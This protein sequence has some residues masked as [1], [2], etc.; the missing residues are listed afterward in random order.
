MENVSV[1]DIVK[2]ADISVGSFYHHFS[3]KDEILH[4]YMMTLT[5]QIDELLSHIHEDNIIDGIIECLCIFDDFLMEQGVEFIKSY[6]NGYN[7]FL[8]DSNAKSPISDKIVELYDKGVKQ[9][10]LDPKIDKNNFIYE[11]MIIQRG[12][13]LDYALRDGSYDMKELTNKFIRAY[14]KSIMLNA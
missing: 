11:C 13:F 4:I 7:A 5:G 6:Y 2:A 1:Q 12:I 3:S 14:F 10:I 9:G 8:V